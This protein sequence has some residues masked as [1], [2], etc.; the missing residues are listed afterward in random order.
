MSE[1]VATVEVKKVSGSKQIFNLLKNKEVC[2]LGL[3]TPAAEIV[4][5]LKAAGTEVSVALINN[6]KFRIRKLKDE[7]KAARKATKTVVA[8][9]TRR[10]KV[11]VPTI[12]PVQGEFDRLIAVKKL[13]AD[14]GGLD[15]LSDLITKVKTLAS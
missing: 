2:P 13:A 9:K 11:Q 8:V 15:A 4:E 12:S 10:K 5:K 3:D 7:R 14:V 6:V 1:N